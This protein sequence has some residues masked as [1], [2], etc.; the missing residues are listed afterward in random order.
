MYGASS[1]K[2]SDTCLCVSIFIETCSCCCVFMLMLSVLNHLTGF[3]LAVRI[4]LLIVT[5]PSLPYNNAVA[6]SV[7]RL[8]VAADYDYDVSSVLSYPL[9]ALH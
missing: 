9:S 4:K 3:S 8:W 7:I 1:Y 2:C 6:A 5:R